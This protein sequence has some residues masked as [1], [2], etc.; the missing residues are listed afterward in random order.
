MRAAIYARLSREDEDKI[1]G[2][3]IINNHFLYELINVIINK[4]SVI[5]E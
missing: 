5:Y 2:N 1:D 3:N 4:R